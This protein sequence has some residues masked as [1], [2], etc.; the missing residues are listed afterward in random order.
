[1][2]KAVLHLHHC[3]ERIVCEVIVSIPS[4]H[5]INM[6]THREPMIS[7]T[8]RAVDSWL[9][10]LSLISLNALGGGLAVLRHLKVRSD[11]DYELH[12]D[13]TIFLT[14]EGVTTLFDKTR[15]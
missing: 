13:D 2:N 4:K 8:N 14:M 6:T 12:D 10:P 1:M 9:L 5:I 3:F 7:P 11:I 15:W